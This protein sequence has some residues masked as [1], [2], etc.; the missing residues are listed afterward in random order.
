MLLAAADDNLNVTVFSLFFIYLKNKINTHM[1][2]IS[3]RF[4]AIDLSVLNEL[5][6]KYSSLRYSFSLAP[7][8]D[9]VFKH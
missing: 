4:N 3:F 9:D 6:L 1:F 7:G 2:F 5:R 8:S